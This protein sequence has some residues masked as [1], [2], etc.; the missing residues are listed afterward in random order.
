MQQRT[1][2]QIEELLDRY[3]LEDY[4]LISHGYIPTTSDYRIR[5]TDQQGIVTFV[6]KD[7]IEVNEQLTA[8]LS[9]PESM[10]NPKKEEDSEAEADMETA[11]EFDE[12][13]PE[14]VEE[15]IEPTAKSQDEASDE[16]SEAELDALFDDM[17]PAIPEAEQLMDS[18]SPMEYE[19]PKE[20][21]TEAASKQQTQAKLPRSVRSESID[22]PSPYW[23]VVEFS[24]RAREWTLRLPIKMHEITLITPFKTLRLVFRD[25]T[26]KHEAA[27]RHHGEPSMLRIAG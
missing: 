21:A 16:I 22:L 13:E 20:E 17:D 1:Q 27:K 5:L 3:P 8:A 25:V 10:Q 9:L 2:G 15:A 12:A 24:D 4:P 7:V 26:V 6:F 19:D 18:D 14:A 11:E 23:H